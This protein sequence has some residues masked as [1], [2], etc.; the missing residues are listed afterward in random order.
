[1]L[2]F[3]GLGFSFGAIDRGLSKFLSGASGKFASMGLSVEGLGAAFGKMSK[4]A[5]SGIASLS[6]GAKAQGKNT[7][8][9]TK[10]TKEVEKEFSGLSKVIS[11]LNDLVSLNKLGLFIESLGLHKLNKIAD[12]IQHIGSAGENLT[13]GYEAQLTALHK[14]A[15]Q[16]GVDL[17]YTGKALKK[18]TAQSSGMAIGLNIDAG[19]AGEAI[20]NFTSNVETLGAV[21]I[22]SA[23][24]FAKFT[25]VL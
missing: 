15:V 8:K 5:T 23:K 20:Y 13:T 18:F 21:G 10:N 22:K 4:W 1:M 17:G 19:Q 24:D 25:G 7:E 3:Q 6:K 16:T 2:N 14:T 9:I 12:G 11:K